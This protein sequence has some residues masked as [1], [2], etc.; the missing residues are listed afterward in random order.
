MATIPK[1]QIDFNPPVYRCRRADKPFKLDGRLDKPFWEEADWTEWF[2]DIEGN[3]RP[4]P[5]FKTRAKMLW[6][7]NNLYIGAELLG[8]EIWANQTERDCVI[9]YDNDFEVFI[10]PDGDTHEY[11]EFEMNALNTVWDL[12]LTKPYLNQ[13][14]PVNA[15]D[16]QGLQTAVYI[17]GELN[18]PA[19]E[20]KMWSVEI[21]MPFAVLN[22]CA[23]GNT[24]DEGVYWRMNFSRVQWKV[25]I[26]DNKYV[27]RLDQN[28]GKPLP[29]D[30]WVW[31]P[32]GI[33]NIHYPE[34]WAFVFFTHTDKVYTIPEDEKIKWQLRQVYYNAYEYYDNHGKFTSDAALLTESLPIDITPLVEATSNS[35]E[36]S[37]DNYNRTKRISLFSNGRF[38]V[39]DV[40]E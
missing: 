19:A 4:E 30:N 38:K 33:V 25:D 16:I 40:K 17:D 27:K 11:Y 2:D 13:G 35:F 21:V 36:I 14:S 6:D 12:L 34:L 5:R 24:P 31:S 37:C 29:E 20:N 23:R 18:N 22:Q 1:P 8:S 3:I 26:V 7:D 9:F 15:F 28:T 39:Y 32:T 10:D